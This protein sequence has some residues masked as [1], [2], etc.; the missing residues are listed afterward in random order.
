MWTDKCILVLLI[1]RGLE[2]Q[3]PAAY[4][5][6]HLSSRLYDLPSLPI[7]IVHHICMLETWTMEV[8][9]GDPKVSRCL[10]ASITSVRF[11]MQQLQNKAAG[12]EVS[13]TI[14]ALSSSYLTMLGVAVLRSRLHQLWTCKYLG[15]SEDPQ[16]L[17]SNTWLWKAKFRP[18]KKEDLR[19][20]FAEPR[21]WRNTGMLRGAG[22]AVGRYS[23]PGYHNIFLT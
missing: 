23:H 15:T 16:P 2:S 17:D 10:A 3:F 5:A 19:R 14:A 11:A 1:A 9:S 6:I 20:A 4:E 21:I 12:L 13:L 22:E 7:K 8:P 18:V